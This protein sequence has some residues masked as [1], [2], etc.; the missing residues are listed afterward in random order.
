MEEREEIVEFQLRKKKLSLR[1]NLTI[2]T[3]NFCVKM[4]QMIRGVDIEF[5]LIENT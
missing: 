4:F 1:K 3:V 2:K 5:F